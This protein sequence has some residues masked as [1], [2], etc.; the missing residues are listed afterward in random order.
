MIKNIEIE[1][2]VMKRLTEGRYVEG[3]LHR[4]QQ[5]GRLRFRAYNRSPR[6]KGKDRLVCQLEHGWMKESSQRIRFYSSVRKSLGWRLIDLAMHRELK[7]AMG[8]LEVENLLD[9]V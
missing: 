9:N 2:G 5:T 6:R 3:S 8:V 1:A 4:D 7:H